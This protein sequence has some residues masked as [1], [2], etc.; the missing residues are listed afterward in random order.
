[1]LILAATPIG[2]LADAS[3]R[4]IQ[5]LSEARVIAAEDT[6]MVQ[7]LAQGLAIE[8]NARLISLND[9]NEREKVDQL[10]AIAQNEDLL[11]V[12]DAGM[13]TVSDPG[14]VLVRAMVQAGIEVSVI[15][16]PSAVLAALA[17]SGLPTDR[18]SFEGF[19]PR[20]ESERTEFFKKLINEDRTMVF[21][22]TANRLA[23][24][25]SAAKAIFGEQRPASV[26]RELTKKF[27]ETFRGSLG[28]LA[29]WSKV[30]P[31][32]ELVLVIAGQTD[33]A[34]ANLTELVQIVEAL[35]G[36]GKSLKD[37]VAVVAKMAGVSKSALYDQ[38]IASRAE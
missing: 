11:L 36:S 34:A 4:L 17:V 12:S 38:T 33:K 24:S 26:S 20:K 15:P 13:P 1:M 16:G 37:A 6:R 19:I 2:N 10:V 23:D 32:G 5:A 31:K 29:E 21:F 14:F 27:E 18:F 30:T 7:K 25:I 22:E 35:R 3:K 8:L 9:H 28:D